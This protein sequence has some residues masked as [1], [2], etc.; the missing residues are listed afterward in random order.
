MSNY[1]VASGI[2][3]LTKATALM[4][5]LEAKGH[6][7]TYDWTTH[8]NVKAWP[9]SMRQVVAAAEF[10]AVES[11]EVFVALLPGGKGTHF[12]LGLACSDPTTQVFVIFDEDG[13]EAEKVEDVPEKFA[14][15]YTNFFML[16]GVTKIHGS[17][18]S[19]V[20]KFA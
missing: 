17:W 2:G 7:V 1:Y 9:K 3:N 8:G 20:E 5:A 12:E 6:R 18:S 14:E 13:V 4:R 19:F 11:A 10:F 15:L 16:D